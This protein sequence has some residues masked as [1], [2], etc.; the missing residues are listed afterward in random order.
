[1]SLSEVQWK[2]LTN[3]PFAASILFC[4]FLLSAKQN[5]STIIMALRGGKAE[6]IIGQ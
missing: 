3:R 5:I 1:M 2:I 6:V 4:R